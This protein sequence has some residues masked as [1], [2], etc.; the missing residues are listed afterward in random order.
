ML[1]ADLQD[2]DTTTFNPSERITHHALS[3]LGKILEHLLD[4]FIYP[5]K[6]LSEQIICLAVFA[7][8][9]CALFRQHEIAS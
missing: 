1:T 5:D 3:L 7:H 6:S 2:L 4:P 8:I 9:L